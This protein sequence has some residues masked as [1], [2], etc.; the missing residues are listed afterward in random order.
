M[1][2]R[3][4]LVCR[5]FQEHAARSGVVQIEGVDVVLIVGFVEYHQVDFQDSDRRVAVETA[6]PPAAVLDSDHRFVLV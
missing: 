1:L 6:N 4:G 3:S 5:F 2:A